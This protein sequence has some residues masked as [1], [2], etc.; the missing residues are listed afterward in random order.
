V[1]KGTARTGKKDKNVV[2]FFQCTVRNKHDI[3]ESDYLIMKDCL[4]NAKPEE[5]VSLIFIVPDSQ[6]KFKPYLGLCL[7]EFSPN[8]TVYLKQK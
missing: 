8:I 4:K 7:N 1:F 2:F 3:K 5:E 6:K